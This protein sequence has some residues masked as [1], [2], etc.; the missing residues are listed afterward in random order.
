MAEGFIVDSRNNVNVLG[1]NR[2]NESFAHNQTSTHK[3]P[4]CGDKRWSPVIHAQYRDAPIPAFPAPAGSTVGNVEEYLSYVKG[5]IRGVFGKMIK[6]D[7][8]SGGYLGHQQVRYLRISHGPH[9]KIQ[10]FDQAVWTPILQPKGEILVRH[11]LAFIWG[12]G[13]V[14][15][16]NGVRAFDIIMHPKFQNRT[17]SFKFYQDTTDAVAQ[18][19]MDI[20]KE[21]HRYE[22]LSYEYELQENKIHFHINEGSSWAGQDDF[23]RS[24]LLS[25]TAHIL[26]PKCH[27]T[28]RKD[29]PRIKQKIKIYEIVGGQTHS[30]WKWDH[31][32][33]GDN[34]PPTLTKLM[35]KFAELFSPDCWGPYWTGHLTD[36]SI[37][38]DTT[39]KSV[40]QDHQCQFDGWWETI[41]RIMTQNLYI[42]IS[43][44]VARFVSGCHY[45]DQ[46]R[47]PFKPYTAL[48]KLR[49]TTGEP[50]SSLGLM[51]KPEPHRFVVTKRS[52][53]AAEVTVHMK[54]SLMYGGS[55][56]V[57]KLWGKFMFTYTYTVYWDS[58]LDEA[59]VDP[60]P[61]FLI[62]PFTKNEAEN[63]NTLT[64]EFTDALNTRITNL[65]AIL[66]DQAAHMHNDESD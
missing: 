13:S 17:Y 37:T 8:K 50:V 34:T 53:S 25:G 60:L 42:R 44:V 4:L 58:Q 30:R 66:H 2:Y 40:I 15:H 61:K 63:P 62:S 48:G 33:T 55:P 43:H 56:P 10:Y 59:R 36:N 39:F 12:E 29:M 23:K 27:E 64:A 54:M 31:T 49:D 21:V 16:E 41:N 46:L 11:I 45:Q 51:W 1:L 7:K 65:M 18:Q 47:E 6:V 35:R 5:H 9:R 24:F 26:G 32:A 38:D 20:V 14:L 19:W 52:A 3:P 22:R 57:G 28:V